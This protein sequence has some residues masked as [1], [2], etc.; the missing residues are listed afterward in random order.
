MIHTRVRRSNLTGAGNRNGDG[1]GGS[2][3][4]FRPR[5]SPSVRLRVRPRACACACVFCVCK[6]GGCAIIL[7][8]CGVKIAAVCVCTRRVGAAPRGRHRR[9][10]A[11]GK[12]L[13]PTVF[14][15]PRRHRFSGRNPPA[16]CPPG[17]G[18]LFLNRRSDSEFRTNRRPNGSI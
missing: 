2:F 3:T 5:R 10:V 8:R 14:C 12:T 16:T 15:G 9:P 1:G 4:H 7:R 18:G 13:R 6:C 11:P 17:R